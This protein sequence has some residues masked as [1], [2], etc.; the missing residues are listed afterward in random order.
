MHLRHVGAHSAYGSAWHFA[1]AVG[2]GLSDVSAGGGLGFAPIPDAYCNSTHPDFV[3]GEL[4]WYYPTQDYY[5]EVNSKYLINA[6][7]QRLCVECL[8]YGRHTVAKADLEGG[9]GSV[10]YGGRKNFAIRPKTMHN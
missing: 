1:Y 3:Y 6:R 4:W 7:P 9:F 5:L 10:V 2:R 8:E